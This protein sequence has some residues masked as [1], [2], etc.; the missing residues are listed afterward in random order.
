MAEV[1]H[2]PAGGRGLPQGG[3]DGPLAEPLLDREARRE[4]LGGERRVLAQSPVPG[5]GPGQQREGELPYGLCVDGLHQLPVAQDRSRSGGR[6]EAGQ[7]ADALGGDGGGGGRR[8]RPGRERRVGPVLALPVQ[9]ELGRREESY[10]LAPQV[11]VRQRLGLRHVP[12][13]RADSETAGELAGPGGHGGL[14]VE[15]QGGAEGGGGVGAV[16]DDVRAAGGTRLVAVGAGAVPLVAGSGGQ[17]AGDQPGL[18][19]HQATDRARTAAPALRAGAHGGV[20]ADRPV[21][22][23]ALVGGVAQA[24]PDEDLHVRS[25]SW[26]CG[27]VAPGGRWTAVGPC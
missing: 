9:G 20:A 17:D 19:E 7:V 22:D 15:V 5:G 12:A 26:S 13:R 11:H 4:P 21:L 23:V 3:L 10:V 8:C 27:A 16:G 25:A 2:D 1:L 6:G 24:A 14:H 18:S